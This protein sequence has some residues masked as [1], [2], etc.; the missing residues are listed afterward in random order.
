M[1]NNQNHN[2]Q[3]Q[4]IAKF[5]KAYQKVAAGSRK[6][7]PD[8]WDLG[9]EAIR[10]KQ[11]IGQHGEW[12]PWLKKSKYVIRTTQKAM[13]I[14]RNFSPE[15]G[16]RV[17]LVELKLTVEEAEDYGRKK[18]GKKKAQSK[19]AE[20]LAEAKT[21]D[22]KTAELQAWDVFLGKFP[23]PERAMMLAL[24]KVRTFTMGETP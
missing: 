5:D 11:V 16:G 19:W 23:D 17:K 4:L 3:E 12:I 15:K 18:N 20:L 6:Q 10:L 9:D 21:F 14:C 24:A 7:A 22:A 1:T 2:S 8:Y 13:R